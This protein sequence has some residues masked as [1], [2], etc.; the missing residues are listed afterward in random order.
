M[1]ENRNI[2][3]KIRGEVA[4]VFRIS[5]NYFALLAGILISTSINFFTVVV[6]DPNHSE[7]CVIISCS[8]FFIMMSAI[9]LSAISW[10]LEKLQRLYDIAPEDVRNSDH[11]WEKFIDPDLKKLSE[12]LI[13]SIII[14]LVGL[15]F[16]LI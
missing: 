10:N 16:L 14:V 11:A 15:I 2:Y 1:N 6:I 3:K 7:K 5:P 12:Y 8:S 9:L 4:S 13:S